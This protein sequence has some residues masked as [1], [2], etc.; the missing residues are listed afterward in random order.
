MLNKDEGGV[1]PLTPLEGKCG[2]SPLM[3]MPKTSP[4][5]LP[6]CSVSRLWVGDA[7]V[8]LWEGTTEQGWTGG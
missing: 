7:W 2:D 1:G 5:S 4:V 3:V 6:P 8:V